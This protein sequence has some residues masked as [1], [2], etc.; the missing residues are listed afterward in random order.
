MSFDLGAYMKER[1][2]AVDVALDR[3][4]PPEAERPE[5]LHKAMRYSVF[6]GG[7]R[8]R[9]VLVIAAGGGGGR[10]RGAGHADRVR[11]RAAS[12]PTRSC[13]TTCPRWTTTIS[14]AASPPVTR[15][16]AR[17]SRSW[18]ATRC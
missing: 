2:A 8:L 3:F 1:A 11:A 16:L 10:D 4:L 5:S 15:S 7:K 18:P 6:A 17:A 14:A 13:M 12:T 9:P